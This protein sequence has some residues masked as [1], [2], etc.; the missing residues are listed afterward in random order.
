MKFDVIELDNPKWDEKVRMCEMY[1]FHHT[2]CFHSIEV[3]EKE[4][5]VLLGLT[6]ANDFLCFPL[7]V[8]PIDGTE[9]FDATSVYGYCGPIASAPIDDL[10][11]EF[12]SFFQH[13]F[14]N[15]CNSEKIVSVFSRLH[16]LI[17]QNNFFDDFGELVDL[18][19][20]VSIDLTI[21][22]DEQRRAFRK[23]LKNRINKLRRLGFI[24]EEANEKQEI[25]SFI[26]IYYS[27][28]DK[29]G[30]TDGYYFSREYFHSFLDNMD[31]NSKLLLAKFEGE[32]VAGAVFT[33]VGEIMQYHLSG[34]LQS[35]L[36]KAP[37]NLIL[38]EAR[39]LGSSL[40]L[41]HLHLGGG[42]GGEDYDSLFEFKSGF[43]K[44]FYQFTVW[45]LIVDPVKYDEL[46]KKKSL[47][48]SASNFFPLYRLSVD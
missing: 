29:L 38:D 9:F 47:Q 25:E 41:T 37:M 31:F 11:K 6:E 23:S 22:I 24:V 35:Y 40:D 34:T 5:A 10:P 17:K 16:P 21:P 46:V 36:N 44:D 8:R 15:Y 4:K 32:I 43:S 3:L 26:D 13:S 2:S 48:N 1:D 14:L 19:K 18:N 7:I 27:T 42:V 33:I 28:M 39:L 12:I 30:A 45:K 20:T